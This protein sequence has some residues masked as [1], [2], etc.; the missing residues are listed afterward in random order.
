MAPLDGPS[1]G[2]AAGPVGLRRLLRRWSTHSIATPTATA[3]GLQVGRWWAAEREALEC[4]LGGDV[5]GMRAD[6]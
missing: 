5:R 4:R 6:W 1:L 3:R 2:A